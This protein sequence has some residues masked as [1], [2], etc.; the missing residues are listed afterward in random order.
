LILGGLVLFIA[1]II[2]NYPEAYSKDNKEENDPDMDAKSM[3]IGKIH[4]DEDEDEDE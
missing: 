1:L 3:N 2:P 4:E